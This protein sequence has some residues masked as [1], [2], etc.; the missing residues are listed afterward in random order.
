[1]GKA[2]AFVTGASRGI[3]R[4]VAIELAR[5]GYNVVGA[6]T[7]A[8]PGNLVE[9]LYEVKDR[10]EELGAQFLPVAGDIANREDHARM[11]DEALAAFSAIDVLVNNAG[12]APLERLD[13]LDTTEESF[14]RLMHINLRGPFFFTQDVA[15][16]MIEQVQEGRAI[17][18]CIIFITS[19]SADTAS[20]NR[21]EYCISKA[22][23]S[24]AAQ[25]FAVRLAQ[26]GINVYEL[27]PGIIETDMTAP[28]RAK[29]DALIAEGLLLQPRWGTPE[30]VGRAVVGL[31]EGYFA[32]ATGAVIEVG[33]GFGVKRL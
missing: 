33:G 32:Y 14:D 22:G 23:L 7:K 20:P 28:V 13:L 27:R 17:V 1:M 18:P 21:A 24:M 31:A 10:V 30:D 25:N 9:G 16:Q 12:V 15:V 8:D 4:G 6:A 29:Y 19:I 26:H 2:T 5:H 11:V 3:G